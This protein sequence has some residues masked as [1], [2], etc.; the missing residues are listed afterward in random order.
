MKAK[1][2]AVLAA[3][4]AI[5]MIFPQSI[6]AKTKIRGVH[7]AY[8]SGYSDG[9]IR[10]EEYLTREEAAAV[11][12]NLLEGRSVKAGMPFTDVSAE[13]WSYEAIR[14]LVGAGIICGND[15]GLF[16]PEDKI[17][18]AEFAVMAAKFAGI[19]DGDIEFGDIGG[20][21]AERYIRAAVAGGWLAGYTDGEFKPNNYVTRAEMMF[22][23]N[24]ALGRSVEVEEDMLNDMKVW[25]DNTDRTKW[26]YYAVQEASNS[27]EYVI[28]EN[29]TETWD[30]II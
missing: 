29:N 28:N 14:T 13:R 9:S 27:H 5:M 21:W 16:R 22:F 19:S 18:R 23:V 17:T 8:I 4:L 3:A 20:H 1:T 25:S 26:Y 7:K 2:C 24:N 15:D 11:F 10:P 6:H 12:C 30:L